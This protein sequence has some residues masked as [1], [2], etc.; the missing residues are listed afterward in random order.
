[1]FRRAA[2]AALLLAALLPVAGCA[3]AAPDA[4][5]AGRTPAGTSQTAAD[6]FLPPPSSDV[7]S[8]ALRTDQCALL[9]ETLLASLGWQRGP[10]AQT[11]TVCGAGSADR[12][13]SVSVSVDTAVSD[14]PAPA[15][16]DRC[17]RLRIVDTVT[18]IALKVQIRG[19]PDPCRPAEEFLATAARRFDDGAG[20]LPPPTPWISLD[21]C[22]LLPKV[23]PVSARSLG[24]PRPTLREVRRLGVRGCVASH[25]DGEVTLS[26]SPVPGRVPDLDGEEIAVA[27]GPARV[28]ALNG[29]CLLRLVD[30]QLGEASRPE[31]QVVTIEV[32]AGG[33]PCA[34]ATA[35]AQALAPVLPK[36]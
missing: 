29:T 12:Q 3:G 16:G 18:M 6:T 22:E 27:G 9:D 11:L 8:R 35:M 31:V 19:E 7:L 1:V 21:A 15:D 10:Q 33:D 32:Q 2:A 28:L 13:R 34:V 14:R 26:V 5:N 36:S 30:R 20:Q 17:T 4:G 24:G 25:L 23:L